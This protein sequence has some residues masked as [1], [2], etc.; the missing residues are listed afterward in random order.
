M[1]IVGSSGKGN[2]SVNTAARWLPIA[3]TTLM[4]VSL[5]L[6]GLSA[7][8]GAKKFCHCILAWPCCVMTSLVGRQLGSAMRVKPTGTAL[9]SLLL[10][11]LVCLRLGRSV[12]EDIAGRF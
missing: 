4:A 3:R 2:A 11:V 9:N 5:C 6:S 7:L 1:K 8:S 12:L 10:F